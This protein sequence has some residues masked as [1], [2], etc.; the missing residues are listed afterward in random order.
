MSWHKRTTGSPRQRGKSF[1]K[2]SY[3]SNIG[4]TGTPEFRD[5]FLRLCFQLRMNYY[6]AKFYG[7]QL[8]TGE[9]AFMFDSHEPTFTANQAKYA[10]K[11]LRRYQKQ[12]TTLYSTR[13]S[14]P[15]HEREAHMIIFMKAYDRVA[16][17]GIIDNPL[18]IKE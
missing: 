10:E 15:Y 1:Y 7:D 5:D 11:I 2:P 3:A 18:V 9:T 16:S 8:S 17:Y 4:Y 6:D 14:T 12:L 13:M